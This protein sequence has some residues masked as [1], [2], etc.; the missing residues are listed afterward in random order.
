MEQHQSGERAMAILSITAIR[1]LVLAAVVLLAIIFAPSISASTNKTKSEKALE[2]ISQK[3]GLPKERLKITN[4]REANF[5]LTNR[6]IWSVNILDSKGKEFYYVD[7]DE[8]GNEADI[9]AAKALENAKYREK[10]G[11]KEIELHEK[12]Q[13]M[14]PDDMVEVGIWLSPIAT[15]QFPDREISEQ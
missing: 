5:R 12:L 3:H 1:R 6:K 8:A 4:E 11:K 2:Y 15:P 13:K 9:K 14:N 7:L 10:Y